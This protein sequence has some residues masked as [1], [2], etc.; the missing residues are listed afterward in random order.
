MAASYIISNVV[1][2]LREGVVVSS[3]LI[4]YFPLYYVL[5]R[6]TGQIWLNGTTTVLA[7]GV[8]YQV[9]E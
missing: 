4:F 9:V 2:V 3:R 6:K 1:V 8:Y 7:R 5:F